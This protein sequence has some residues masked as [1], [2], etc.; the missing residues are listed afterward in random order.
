M[1]I[2]KS[3]GMI[4]GAD[5]TSAERKALQIEVDRQLAEY[6]RKHWKSTDAIVLY[7]LAKTF[8]FGKTRLK[9]FFDEFGNRIEELIKH[10][11][12]SDEDS[13]WICIE[14]LKEE[15]D[16]DLDEWEKEKIK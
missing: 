3:S 2:K 14:K 15:Y 10:Y 13:A 1:R 5:L 7:S 16:I 6:T 8:G 9:K 12:L 4:F 11:E